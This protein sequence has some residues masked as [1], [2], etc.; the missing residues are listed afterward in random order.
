MAGLEISI[1][2]CYI[3][4]RGK[5]RGFF[6]AP[7]L[8]QRS[9]MKYQNFI[10]QIKQYVSTQLTNG[11]KVF[12]QPVVKNNGIV[13]DGLFI[14][15]PILN[16]SPTIYLN[17]Y[18]HRYLSGVSMEDIC[19]DVLNTYY[20]NLPQKDF[21]VSVFTDFSKAKQRIT[22]KL[23]NKKRNAKLLE[24]V[25]YIPYLDLAIV[26]VCSVTEFLNEYATILIHNNHMEL[27]NIDVNELYEIALANSPELLP[28]QFESIGSILPINSEMYM[29]WIEQMEM[30]VLSNKL[31]IHGATCIVYPGLLEKIADR[32]CSD[33][34]IIPSSIHEV[35]VIPESYIDSR[36]I[37]PPDY[38]AMIREV[39]E[40]QLADDEI[41]GE[42]VYHY[43]R[44]TKTLEF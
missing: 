4:P 29:P 39:N 30:Y 37:L 17:P 40:T 34:V 19:E 42:C 9:N 10:E 8:R 7:Q 6:F 31:K 35:L 22:M 23:V 3:N 16:V 15:D 36:D 18:Y 1:I 14:V 25:P 12:L 26:F 20:S 44:D 43:R 38:E 5:P 33:L 11:Q 21:D 2:I 13:Y 28:Y 41:L 32:L 27:W 24:S